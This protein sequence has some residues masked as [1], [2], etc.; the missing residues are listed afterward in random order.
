MKGVPTLMDMKLEEESAQ[1]LHQDEITPVLSQVINR[2]DFHETVWCSKDHVEQTAY[3]DGEEVTNP[4]EKNRENINANLENGHKSAPP[5]RDGKKLVKK[6][7]GLD[8]LN[9]IFPAHF[10]ICYGKLQA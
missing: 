5:L 7:Q 4:T 10:C 1:I 8:C 9:I 6:M 2:K 3:D